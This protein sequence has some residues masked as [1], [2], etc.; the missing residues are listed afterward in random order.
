MAES[1]KLS[2]YKCKVKI[3][4]NYTNLPLQYIPVSPKHYSQIMTVWKT[5][6]TSINKMLPFVLVHLH[7]VLIAGFTC[8]TFSNL[9]STIIYEAIEIMLIIINQPLAFT[10][11]G[12]WRWKVGMPVPF[13]LIY[14]PVIYLLQLQAC[15]LH[16]F[17]FIFLLKHDIE[18]NDN[19]LADNNKA[20]DNS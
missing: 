16:Q 3:F 14:K 20:T 6:K 4:T 9:K 5:G 18:A 2:L 13:P 11:W 10:L 7:C 12:R 19:F 15:F 8:I 1:N 17:C